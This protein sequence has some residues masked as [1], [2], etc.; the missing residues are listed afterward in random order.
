MKKILVLFTLCLL[1]GCMGKKTV[2][3]NYAYSNHHEVVEKTLVKIDSK[4]SDEILFDGIDSVDVFYKKLDGNQVEFSIVN[5]TD[6]YYSGEVDFDVCEFK[7]SFEAI[8]PKG[9]VSQV[10]ECPNFKEDSSYSFNGQLYERNDDYQFDIEYEVYFY[11]DD[12]TLFDYVLNLDV[13]SDEDLIQLSHFVYIENILGNYEGEMWIRVYP[14]GKY[15]EAYELNTPE[16]WNDLDANYVVGKIWIDTEND[17]AEI[18]TAND[19]LIERVN[20]AKK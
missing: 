3:V 19:E 9:E 20:Y 16:A 5:Y 14:M 4:K 13:I 10:I 15:K 6:Y 11:E 12:E 8:V 18:Y 17:I 1:V 7:I 2:E